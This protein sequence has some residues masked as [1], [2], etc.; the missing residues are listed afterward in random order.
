MPL[1]IFHYAHPLCP[2]ART[3][4]H[5]RTQT[6]THTHARAH[7]HTRTWRAKSVIKYA[8]QHGPSGGERQQ[9]VFILK[10]NII[11]FVVFTLQWCTLH[12]HSIWQWSRR[13]VAQVLREGKW[14][15]DGVVLKAQSSSTHYSYRGCNCCSRPKLTLRSAVF[16]VLFM[17]GRCFECLL[18]CT[19]FVRMSTKCSVSVVV[20]CLILG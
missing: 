20:L 7:T 12:V 16:Y 18:V 14:S 3:H 15:D 11:T 9:A 8:H 2:V 13:L 1:P 5:A 17:A 19:V 10:E 6:R 4:T